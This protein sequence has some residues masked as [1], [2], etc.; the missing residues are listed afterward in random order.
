MVN[1]NQLHK[2][3]K[4]SRIPF[5]FAL[6][7]QTLK[8]KEKY[9][10][11]N[12]FQIHFIIWWKDNKW[13]EDELHNQMLIFIFIWMHYQLFLVFL[14]F[15]RNYTFYIFF[16]FLCNFCKYKI[17]HKIEERTVKVWDFELNGTKN[18]LSDLTT[19][20]I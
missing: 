11:N 12:F 8:Y 7:K 14:I 1:N 17:I 5:R 18:K 20:H 19:R 15:P 3:I 9:F 13:K 16:N 2:I 6:I 10:D 4:W